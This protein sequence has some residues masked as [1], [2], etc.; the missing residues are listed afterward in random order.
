MYA[1]YDI[2]YFC[3]A[4]AELWRIWILTN[5]GQVYENGVKTIVCTIEDDMAE[6]DFKDQ[7][8]SQIE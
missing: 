5:E 7:A 8:V 1:Q 4:L 2:H 3:L 6:L